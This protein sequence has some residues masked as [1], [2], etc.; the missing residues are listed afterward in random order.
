MHALLLPTCKYGVIRPSATRA[1]PCDR[2]RFVREIQQLKEELSAEKVGTSSAQGPVADAESSNQGPDGPT[3]LG[4][5]SPSS[6]TSPTLPRQELLEE[7]LRTV[8]QE[9]AHV[10]QL[11]DDCQARMN[12]ILAPRHST[13]P[14]TQ[15]DIEAVLQDMQAC[16]ESESALQASNRALQSD[17]TFLAQTNNDLLEEH[18]VL[19]EA[20]Q[21]QKLEIEQLRERQK[22][23]SSQLARAMEMPMDAAA[24]PRPSSRM[25]AHSSTP[26]FRELDSAELPRPGSAVAGLEAPGNELLGPGLSRKPP[27]GVKLVAPENAQNKAGADET[28]EHANF[29]KVM[30][31]MKTI[32]GLQH[33]NEAFRDE[34]HSLL[35]ELD[36]VVADNAL[37][38][39]DN[40]QLLDQNSALYDA[41][42]NAE[43]TQ[44]RLREVER[45]LQDARQRAEK[46]EQ[47]LEQVPPVQSRALDLN[48]QSVGGQ[49]PAAKSVAVKPRPGQSFVVDSESAGVEKDVETMEYQQLLSDNMKLAAD[50]R[51]LLEDNDR[52]FSDNKKIIADLTQLQ[53]QNELLYK[54]NAKLSGD[55]DRLLQEKEEAARAGSGAG[56]EEDP[57]VALREANT[58]LTLD[59]Q[60]MARELEMLESELAR[61]QAFM[62]KGAAFASADTDA[63]GRVDFSEFTA[64][65]VNQGVP[66][67]ELRAIFDALDTNQDGTLDLSEFSKFRAAQLAEGGGEKTEALMEDLR[68]MEEENKKLGDDNN[69]LFQ[70]N[71]QL[72][73]DNKEILLENKRLLAELSRFGPSEDAPPPADAGRPTSSPKPKPGNTISTASSVSPDVQ[74]AMQ[75][76]EQENVVLFRD[77]RTLVDE[78]KGL[79]REISRLQEQLSVAEESLTAGGGDSPFSMRGGPAVSKAPSERGIEFSTDARIRS[80]EL[81]QQQVHRFYGNAGV[82]INAEANLRS[83]HVSSWR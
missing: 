65:P 57:L 81:R 46:A 26:S 72:A 40:Q 66:A 29:E 28:D 41:L 10:Q 7:T 55:H 32:E 5:T 11:L 3:R 8:A 24:P 76:L 51:Q 44:A 35:G 62:D 20:M 27:P 64:L 49:L 79:L 31:L 67:D 43:A 50:N 4:Q 56:E 75:K 14:S 1:D 61:R 80:Y 39:E 17:K 74:E 78:N 71:R 54:D 25:S 2:G 45:E 12:A 52:L 83:P 18:A 33:E 30:E 70:D 15:M 63:S 77:N 42:K 36:Q 60:L 13:R 16:V 68:K 69:L 21:E 53:E 82:V 38:M 47:E 9:K 37:L 22:R 6:I 34:V 59:C 48:E 23:P 58:K 19:K 73:L